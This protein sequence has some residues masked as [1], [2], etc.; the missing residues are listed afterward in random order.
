MQEDSTH[1]EGFNTRVRKK[2]PSWYA[3]NSDVPGSSGSD[4]GRNEEEEEEDGKGDRSSGEDDEDK[5][6]EGE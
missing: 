1:V 3:P 6:S 2:D 5:G 4:E